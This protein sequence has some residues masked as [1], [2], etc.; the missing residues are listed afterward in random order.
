MVAVLRFARRTC[1]YQHR[2]ARLLSFLQ[3][4]WGFLDW[5]LGCWSLC[6]PRIDAKYLSVISC[7]FST[8]TIFSLLNTIVVKLNFWALTAWISWSLLKSRSFFRFIS[9]E[10]SRVSKAMWLLRFLWYDASVLPSRMCFLRID[11]LEFAD[12]NW[13]LADRSLSWISCNRFKC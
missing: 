6:C 10:C 2:C 9:F 7:V 11:L 4:S 5:R 1:S 13:L 12:D 8:N 3:E